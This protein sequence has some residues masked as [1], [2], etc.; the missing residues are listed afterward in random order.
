MR[1]PCAWRD[2]VSEVGHLSI[3][4]T[5]PLDIFTR[6]GGSSQT[7]KQNR[8]EQ[9]ISSAQVLSSSSFDDRWGCEATIFPSMQCTVSRAIRSSSSVGITNACKTESSVV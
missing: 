5:P 6:L 9:E 2:K 1:F 3:S 4:T 8:K 7:F